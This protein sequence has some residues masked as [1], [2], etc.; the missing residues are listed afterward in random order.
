MNAYDEGWLAF[1]ENKDVEDNPYVHIDGTKADD[2][3]SG[4]LDAKSQEWWITW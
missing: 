3:Q 1:E 2:W 4:Y